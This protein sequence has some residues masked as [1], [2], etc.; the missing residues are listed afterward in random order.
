MR[1]V[2]T[3]MLSDAL[4][5]HTALTGQ[6]LSCSVTP[7]DGKVFGATSTATVVIQPGCAAPVGYCTSN[8]NSSGQVAHIAAS[9]TTSLSHDDLTLRA[10]GC[11]A[12]KNGIFF[13]GAGQTQVPLGN[14]VRCVTTPVQRLNPPVT[15]DATG[16]VDRRL[17]LDAPPFSTG[18][19]A[20]SAGSTWYFQ[21]WFR[22]PAAGGANVNLSDGVG[23]TFCP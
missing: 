17:E 18:P 5:H 13:Y 6:T 10:T 9:G 23:C 2:T 14:G 19:F 16:A 21:F 12:N 11:P 15:T 4:P 20:L 3:A 1:D 8:T 22:D 7:D